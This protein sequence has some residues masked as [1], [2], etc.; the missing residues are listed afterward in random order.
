MLATKLQEAWTA[1]GSGDTYKRGLGR[2]KVSISD[3]G[4]AKNP[5]PTGEL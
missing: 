2:V 1:V 4:S 5:K 3:R